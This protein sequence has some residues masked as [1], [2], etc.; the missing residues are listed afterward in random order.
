MLFTEV[1]SAVLF[2][3]A[4]AGHVLDGQAQDGRRGNDGLRIR[5]VRR[6]VL[7]HEHAQRTLLVR[8]RHERDAALTD[9][10]LIRHGAVAVLV[11]EDERVAAVHLERDVRIFCDE[12]VLRAGAR[13]VEVQAD[14]LTV[15]LQAEVQR[16]DVGIRLVMQGEAADVAPA[17]DGD[18]F[19]KIGDLPIGS[20][21]GNAPF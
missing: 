3:P 9:D 5:E 7:R 21:H 18:E 19:L 16:Q 4:L 15:D 13:A 8:V 10:A 6:A 17:H 1:C 2:H 20:A 12:V 11:V 14:G